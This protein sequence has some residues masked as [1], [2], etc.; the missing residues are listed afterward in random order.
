MLLIVEGILTIVAWRKGWRGWALLPL[1][2]VLGLAFVIGVAVAAAG[3]TERDAVGF[4][5]VLDL[6]GM[7]ALIGM[8]VRGPK[9]VH[10]ENKPE[11]P[12]KTVSAGG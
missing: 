8:T 5:L 10:F 3:G 7:A 1:G 2:I 11:L 12:V 4:G 6:M 9:K